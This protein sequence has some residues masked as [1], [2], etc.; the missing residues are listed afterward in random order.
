MVG[1]QWTR[2]Q[3]EETPMTEP[4][5]TAIQ[6]AD[7]IEA[8]LTRGDERE[9]AALFSKAAHTLPGSESCRLGDI[10]AER[11]IREKVRDAVARSAFWAV[12]GN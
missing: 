8:A 10:F 9:V 1:R 6:W 5:R 3:E 2:R 4:R 12:Q 7:I 11:G